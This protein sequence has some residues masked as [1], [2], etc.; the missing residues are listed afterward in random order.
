[1]KFSTFFNYFAFL[2]TILLSILPQKNQLLSS[3]YLC[4]VKLVSFL[5]NLTRY[6][7]I[8][9]KTRSTCN[10]PPNAC[11]RDSKKVSLSHQL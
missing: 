2:P 10:V 7:F 1:M 4:L 3:P 8:H 11:P 5:L 9:F 6:I